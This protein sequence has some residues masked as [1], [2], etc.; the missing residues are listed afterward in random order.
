MSGTNKAVIQAFIEEV[1]NQQ[2]LDRADDLVKENFAE[3][4]P[5]PPS[6]A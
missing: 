1:L 6:P 5:Q 3:L 2:R 4:D